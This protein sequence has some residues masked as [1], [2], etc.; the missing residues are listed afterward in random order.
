MKEVGGGSENI[1]N[2]VT[3]LLGDPLDNYFLSIIVFDVNSNALRGHPLM[4]SHGDFLTL[5]RHAKK[6]FYYV[7]KMVTH[8]TP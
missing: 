4:T 1:Q 5:L 8:Y 3:F 2:C 7:T 6:L